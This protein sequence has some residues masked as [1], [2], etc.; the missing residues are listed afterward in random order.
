MK[1]DFRKTMIW[2]HTYS[3]L[4]LGWLLF[5]I[6]VTG[7]LSY[8]NPEISQWMKPELGSQRADSNNINQSLALLNNDAQGATY[9]RIN[10]ATARNNQLSVSW[11]M[12]ENGKNARHSVTLNSKTLQPLEIRDSQGGNFFRSFHYTL[13][14]RNYG[15]RYVAGIAAMMMLVAIF[16]GIFTHRRFF[17]DFFTV[18]LNNVFKTLTDLHAVVGIITIPFCF[19]LSLSAL[20]IYISMYMPWSMDHHYEKGSR[21][22]NALVSTSLPK[23]VPAGVAAKPLTDF[24]IVLSIVKQ[25]WPEPNAIKRISYQQ[26]FDMN[27]RIVVTRHK[28]L[29]LS[30]KSDVLAFS[31]VDGRVLAGIEP[32]RNARMLRR[33]F[34]GLHE[35]L[36]ASIGLRYLLFFMGTAS[37]LLIASGLIM[38]LNKR[39]PKVK[40]R[41]IGH[42]LVERL[43]IAG[44]VGL[45]LAIVSYF[46]ANRLLDLQLAQRAEMEVSV[47]LLTWAAVLIYAFVRPARRAW[48]EL[49]LLTAMAYLALPLVDVVINAQW[50]LDAWQYNNWVYLGFD[51]ALLITG[52]MALFFYFWLAKRT[53]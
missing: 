46:Y 33:I 34:Y 28:Q 29:S 37:C 8:F 44:I 32:E 9:W 51:L 21:E 3:G 31:S 36:F 40:Q 4:L 48:L 2:L 53:H 49:L 39:L 6:F 43:N 42:F 20:F 23:L 12:P 16:S 18:R 22:L 35:A 13:Q 7:T 11:S 26:P 50:L 5:A 17:R 14:L 24:E 47:F 1:P 25:Q 10:L 19:V 41:H 15:G 38:W 45:M 52:T 30:N 27:G